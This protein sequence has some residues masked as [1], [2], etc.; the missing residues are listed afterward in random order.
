MQILQ[1]KKKSIFKQSHCSRRTERNI[2]ILHHT[3]IW[4]M[5]ILL[6]KCDFSQ[7]SYKGKLR[8]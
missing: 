8:K 1:M 5:I 3:T 4:S 7:P 6:K 2:Y